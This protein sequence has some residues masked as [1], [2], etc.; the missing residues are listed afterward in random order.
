MEIASG[1]RKRVALGLLLLAVLALLRPDWPCRAE[2]AAIRAYQS[3][4][5]PWMGKIV[6]CRFKLTCS[7]YAVKSLD[8]RGFW[9]GNALI[10]KRLLLCSP[11]GA[12]VD[13]LSPERPGA[14]Q[15]TSVSMP[16]SMS[17]H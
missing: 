16:E 15:T 11:I 7:H 1:R 3:T 14:A 17:A 9:F 10:A 5:S 12:L 8:E 4:C 6:R 13:S 2:L